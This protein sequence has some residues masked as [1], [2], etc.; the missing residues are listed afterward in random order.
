MREYKV[1]NKQ[2]EIV[3][4]IGADVILESHKIK[5]SDEVFLIYDNGAL[6]NIETVREVKSAYQILGADL[7]TEQVAQKYLDIRQANDEKAIQ[8]QITLEQQAEKIA[9][10]KTGLANTEYVLMMGGLI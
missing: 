10:L 3:E 1:W 6:T 4:G 2:D 5:P 9:E 7:T 8:E